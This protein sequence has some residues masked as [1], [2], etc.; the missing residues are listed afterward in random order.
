MKRDHIAVEIL[1]STRKAL[2]AYAKK[3]GLTITEAAD[4]LIRTGMGRAEANQRHKAAKKAKV[5]AVV[6]ETVETVETG[7]A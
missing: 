5:P 4:S 7:A 1:R 2:G 3:R 6:A